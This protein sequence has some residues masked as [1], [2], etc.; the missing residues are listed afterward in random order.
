MKGTAS[1]TVGPRSNSALAPYGEPL[2]QG[3]LIALVVAAVLTPSDT[4]AGLGVFT[5]Q[6]M[7]WS[8]VA[9]IA[10]G[11]LALARRRT[12][13]WDAVDFA[14]LAFLAWNLAATLAVFGVGDMRAA[15]NGF[16]QT[17]AFVA[18]LL[19]GRRLLNTPAARGDAVA[20]VI[21]LG[22]TLSLLGCLQYFVIYPAAQAELRAD[23]T[24]VLA[25]QGIV[26]GSPTADAF[27][28]RAL[29]REPLGT[30]ALTNSLAVVLLPA[31]LLLLVIVTPPHHRNLRLAHA[32]FFAAAGVIV[33]TC[34]LLT[35]SRTTLLAAGV[36]IAA[37][38]VLALRMGRRLAVALLVGTAGL[39]L[40]LAVGVYW[41]GGLDREVL[42][43]APTSVLYRWQYWQ[44]TLGMIADAPWLGYGPGNFKTVY[45]QYMLPEA[46]EAIGDPHNFLLEIAAT[47]GL[48][49][50]VLFMLLIALIARQAAQSPQSEPSAALPRAD[51]SLPH[52][53]WRWAG[54]AVGCFIAVPLTM[55]VSS[56]DTLAGLPWL[57]VVASVAFAVGAV[58]V[59]PLLQTREL[60]ATAL[61]VVTGV[62]LLNLLAA[63]GIGFP[64]VAILLALLGAL[65]AGPPP[66][67]SADAP[68]PASWHAAASYAVF[69]ASIVACLACYL[70][71]YSPV[72]YANTRLMEADDLAAQGDPL[73][74][75]LRLDEAAAGDRWSSEPWARAASIELQ[76]F[77]AAPN[78]ATFASCQKALEEAIARNPR[79]PLLHQAAGDAYLAAYRVT[80]SPAYLDS[81]ILFYRGAVQ[82][83]P[84]SSGHHARLAWACHLAEQ[85][86]AVEEAREALRLDALSPHKDKKLAREPLRD[87]GLAPAER[88]VPLDERMR[89]IIAAAGE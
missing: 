53:S 1:I 10:M 4:P 42:S 23:P 35:K 29:S 11:W 72:M 62:L 2:L 17:V 65:C 79:S 39:V 40:L 78:V 5:A 46:S 8:V 57:W 85:P 50:L 59:C 15:I 43:E 48:P 75:L 52:P 56:V 41:A 51:K 13:G 60:P 32:P 47:A 37:T 63:G 16:F 89:Q 31:L 33:L 36:G 67:L 19:L 66:A 45:P 30:F 6:S 9:M 24:Q 54:A 22:L 7:L 18:T 38:A 64:N 49:A 81:A 71:A 61:R 80:S 76:R 77:L 44:S 27:L 26:P 55:L 25:E 69:A 68:S 73:Q 84:N 82:R 88:S 74:A 86:V 20:I 14:A 21:A 83:Y 87:P 3:S 34:L 28:N 58:V 70:M 12:T